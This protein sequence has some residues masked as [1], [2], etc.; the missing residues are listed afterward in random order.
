MSFIEGFRSSLLLNGR[1][2]QHYHHRDHH[3]RHRRQFY[4]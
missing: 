2:H 1:N 4:M 3:R